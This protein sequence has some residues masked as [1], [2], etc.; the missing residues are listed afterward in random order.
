MSNDRYGCRWKVSSFACSPR[1][2]VDVG[3]IESTCHPPETPGLGGP[4]PFRDHDVSVPLLGLDRQC[5]GKRFGD[6]SAI[7]KLVAATHGERAECGVGQRELHDGVPVD[8][9][10]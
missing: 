1:A 5:E 6:G 10:Q 2:A 4:L 8:L 3:C 9:R 7:A